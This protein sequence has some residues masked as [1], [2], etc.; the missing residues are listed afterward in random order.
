M[1]AFARGKIFASIAA[2]DFPGGRVQDGCLICPYH[3]WK[4]RLPSGQCVRMPRI[5]HSLRQRV[6][7]L[8]RI[9]SR[10]DMV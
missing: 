2:L 4:L 8:P 6:H 9:A 5:L 10:K 3:G 1:K 7:T